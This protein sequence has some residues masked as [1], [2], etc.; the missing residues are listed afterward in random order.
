MESSVLCSVNLGVDR[1]VALVTES[2]SA[3]QLIEGRSLHQRN[4]LDG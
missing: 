4:L 3:A 1:G 2:C